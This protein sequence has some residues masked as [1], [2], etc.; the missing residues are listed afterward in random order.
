[1][2]RFHTD[3]Y[4]DFLARV[5]PETYDEL[6]GHGT[7]C[8]FSLSLFLLLS[9][10]LTYS[11]AVLIGEDCPPFEGLYEFCSISAGGSL[12]A[13]CPFPYTFSFSQFRC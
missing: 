11:C 2:T 5:T 9:L 3:E 6:S 7:R 1:M 8:T 13:F 10:V 12:S 4:I